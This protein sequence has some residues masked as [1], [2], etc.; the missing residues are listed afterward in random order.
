MVIFLRIQEII[1][2]LA[3]LFNSIQLSHKISLSDIK[4]TN[5]YKRII[6]IQFL[7]IFHLPF[8]F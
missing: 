5:L 6:L 4:I 8:N 1:F 2:V 7:F 3:N